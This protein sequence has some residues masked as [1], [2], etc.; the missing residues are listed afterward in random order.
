[1]RRHDASCITPY[2]HNIPNRVAGTA[3]GV[4]QVHLRP[5]PSTG[6]VLCRGEGWWLRERG[7]RVLS[8]VASKR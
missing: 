7:A 8:C 2:L 1:M 3:A 5:T 4:V 6:L